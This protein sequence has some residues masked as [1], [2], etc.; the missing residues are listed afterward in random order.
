MI[1]SK[2]FS[3]FGKSLSRMR[4]FYEFD[5]RC[6]RQ[7]FALDGEK[8]RCVEGHKDATIADRRGGAN[9]SYMTSIEAC[10]TIVT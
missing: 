3:R 1:P 2:A 4:R 10:A 9:F 8:S 6:F 7:Y 5:S